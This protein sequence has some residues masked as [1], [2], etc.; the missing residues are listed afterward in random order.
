M[1]AG[2]QTTTDDSPL[3]ARPVALSR[4][5]RAAPPDLHTGCG[6]HSGWLHTLQLM[7]L[8]GMHA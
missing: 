6:Q 5:D 3:T 2:L 8:S 7:H 1:S 4:S